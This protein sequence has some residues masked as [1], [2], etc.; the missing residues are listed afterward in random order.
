VKAR[1]TARAV[2]ARALLAG[3]L[4]GLVACTP[5]YLPPG[6]GDALVAESRMRLEGTSRLAASA[7]GPGLL[8]TLD[9]A[10][11]PEEGWLAVQWFPPSGGVIASE[12]LWLTP[13]DAGTSRTIR[14]PDDLELRAGEWRAVVSWYGRVVRQF[15][16]ELP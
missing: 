15:R 3:I 6:P 14:P 9:V 1:T 11:V 5:L 4:A 13:A 7:H 10:E 12:S 2:A 16:V 8:L